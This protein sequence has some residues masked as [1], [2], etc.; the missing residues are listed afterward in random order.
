MN[1]THPKIGDL[2]VAVASG[3]QWVCT[4][5][6]GAKNHRPVWLLRPRYGA[7]DRE[8]LRIERDDLVSYAVV[9]RRGEWT[10]P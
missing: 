7:A 6:A 10:Q 8:Q 4:D 3:K 2:V 1:D 5:I 9:A